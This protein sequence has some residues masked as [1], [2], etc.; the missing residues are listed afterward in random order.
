MIHT[1]VRQLPV[2]KGRLILGY[3]R[4]EPGHDALVAEGEAQLS[5]WASSSG[6]LLG[7]VFSDN[8]V[9]PPLERR[10]FRRLQNLVHRLR[11]IG[12]ATPSTWHISDDRDELARVLCHLRS[13]RCL[14][15][16]IDTQVVPGTALDG[17][18]AKGS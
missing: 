5:Q 1:A 6:L 7:A 8:T 17:F 4:A 13:Q 3:V 15:L 14:L 12:L 2:R 18:S 11:P 16:V 10:G 9:L